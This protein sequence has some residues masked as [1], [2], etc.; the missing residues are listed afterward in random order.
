LKPWKV[1]ALDAWSLGR[2]ESYFKSKKKRRYPKVNAESKRKPE[3]PVNPTEH[4]DAI[5][6]INLHWHRAKALAEIVA[7]AQGGLFELGQCTDPDDEPV[8]YV[9]DV[10]KEEIDRIKENALAELERPQNGLPGVPRTSRQK[11]R[12]R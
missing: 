5:D 7:C 3:K 8:P 12:A 9:M 4:L 10:L 1:G 6:A 2:L 11:S